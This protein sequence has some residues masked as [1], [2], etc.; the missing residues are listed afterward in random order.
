MLEQL[1]SECNSAL[2][3]H[4]QHKRE[5]HGIWEL[6]CDEVSNGE[7]EE[8]EESLAIDNLSDLTGVKKEKKPHPFKT[9]SGLW[10]V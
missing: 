6:A 4:P 2:K 10:L 1:K 7:S 9:E 3:S 5:I 8:N